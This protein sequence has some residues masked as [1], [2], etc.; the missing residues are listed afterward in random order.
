MY[1]GDARSKWPS[2]LLTDSRV[3]HLWDEP[4]VVGTRYLAQLPAIID[5]RAPETM[6]P[7]GDAMWDAF[8]VYAAGDRWL[9]PVPV[10]LSWGYP[11]MV[12]REH[13]LRQIE[14]L[15]AK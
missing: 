14:P 11:I 12:T 10:P 6:P 7:G 9:D 15:L 5:R 1:P 8:Y 13:L 4:R 2:G 3:V